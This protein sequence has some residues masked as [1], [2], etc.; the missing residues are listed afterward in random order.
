MRGREED[1]GRHLQVLETAQLDE[2]RIK[3]EPDEGAD[4]MN[5]D[6]KREDN[7]DCLIECKIRT[8]DISDL[9]KKVARIAEV[10]ARG[11]NAPPEAIK[12]VGD[13][14]FG[15]VKS[16]TLEVTL[17][18]CF[19]YFEVHLPKRYMMKLKDDFKYERVG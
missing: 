16:P 8:K 1:R 4:I 12:V 15:V 6:H 13:V 2:Q 11:A 10:E 17:R 19:D 7:D 3:D 14:A 18:D 9:V 5:V